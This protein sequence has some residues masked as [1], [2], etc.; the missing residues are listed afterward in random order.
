VESFDDA[1][2]TAIEGKILGASLD[3][4]KA[5]LKEAGGR[6]RVTSSD[7]ASY[8]LTMDFVPTRVNVRVDSGVITSVASWG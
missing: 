1:V 3:A 4:A 8:M 7:G 2:K 5:V 6:I